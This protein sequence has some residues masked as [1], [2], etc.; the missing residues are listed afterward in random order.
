VF[1]ITS[2]LSLV[3]PRTSL[4]SHKSAFHRIATPRVM[5]HQTGEE[6]QM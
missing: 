5:L 3:S 2:I 6:D 1:I 4:N